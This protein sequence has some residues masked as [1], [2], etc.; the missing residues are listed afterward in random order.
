M[1][2]KGKSVDAAPT[3]VQIGYSSRRVIAPSTWK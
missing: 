3:I 1:S 2:R